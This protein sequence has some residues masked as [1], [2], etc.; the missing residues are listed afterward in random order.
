MMKEFYQN[1]GFICIGIQL[2]KHNLKSCILLQKKPKNRI[3]HVRLIINTINLKS[4]SIGH[5]KL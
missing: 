3:K 2:K 5:K 1:S 4:D